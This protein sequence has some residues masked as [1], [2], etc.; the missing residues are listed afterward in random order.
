MMSFATSR[1]RT[2]VR[3]QQLIIYSPLITVYLLLVVSGGDGMLILFPAVTVAAGYLVCRNTPD[4]D[5]ATFIAAFAAGLPAGLMA[6]TGVPNEFTE[7]C[8]MS[9]AKSRL[10]LLGVG[11]LLAWAVYLSVRN[12]YVPASELVSHAPDAVVNSSNK[13]HTR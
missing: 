5:A 2:L 8:S 3:W 1:S 6:G 7:I 9:H 12:E 10:I 13:E 11:A 4:I